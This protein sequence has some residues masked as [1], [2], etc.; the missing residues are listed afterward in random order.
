MAEDQPS[1][2]LTK[3]LVRSALGAIPGIV[4]AQCIHTHLEYSVTASLV[5]GVFAGLAGIGLAQPEVSAKNVAIGTAGM[6]AA[7]NAPLF[8]Q[9][10]ILDTTMGSGKQE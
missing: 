5:V 1:M 6:I 4:L 9:E 7:H 2:T 3:R 8:M 10:R